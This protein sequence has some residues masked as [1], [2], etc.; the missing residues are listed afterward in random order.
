M[1]ECRSL[2]RMAAAFV[3]ELVMREALQ[4]DVHCVDQLLARGRV[5]LA[6]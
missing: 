1:N 3:P 6:P 2:Q 4:L 5:S